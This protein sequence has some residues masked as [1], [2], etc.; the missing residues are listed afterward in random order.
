M[1]GNEKTSEK[2]RM[3]LLLLLPPFWQAVA[4]ILNIFVPLKD[5]EPDINGHIC[6]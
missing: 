5:G 3:I 4:K 1:S 6:I 2:Y